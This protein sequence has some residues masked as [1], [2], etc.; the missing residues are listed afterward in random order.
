M[1]RL[2]EK[3]EFWRGLGNKISKFRESIKLPRND[4][5]NPRLTAGKT[6]EWV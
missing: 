4:R 5:I 3:I 2:Y 1:K 6:S